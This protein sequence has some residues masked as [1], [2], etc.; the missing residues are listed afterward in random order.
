VTQRYPL[1]LADDPDDLAS[2]RMWDGN[3]YRDLLACRGGRMSQADFIAKHRYRTAILS[4]DMTGFTHAS[5]DDG[6]LAS[7][8]RILDV[9]RVCLPIFQEFGAQKVRAFAD[10]L[11]G[12]FAEPIRALGCAME[13]HRRIEAFHAVQRADRDPC[14][15]CVGL[16]YGP[17][18]RLGPD[19]AMGHEMNLASK[20]GEDIAQG[21]E[22]L[23]TESFH[24]AVRHLPGYRIERRSHPELTAPYYI[25]VPMD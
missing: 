18:F 16:G 24:A 11:Y 1:A 7:L 13:I 20:L 12:T 21:G 22:T 15:C 8:L 19:L 3:V 17:V 10:D 4:L 5:Q 9:H 23:L 14:R 6:D 2:L 25:A